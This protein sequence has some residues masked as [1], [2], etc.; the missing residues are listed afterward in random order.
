MPRML[1]LLFLFVAGC[2]NAADNYRPF[3]AAVFTKYAVPS[4]SPSCTGGGLCEGRGWLQQFDGTSTRRD[5]PDCEVRWEALPI[6]IAH[7]P[8]AS[9]A[10]SKQVAGRALAR[11]RLFHRLR[12]IRKAKR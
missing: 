5:C 6:A 12:S 3:A 10:E 7:S 8:A 1:V 9:V 2:N 4:I 11:R